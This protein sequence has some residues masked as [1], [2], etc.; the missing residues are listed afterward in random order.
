[1]TALTQHRWRPDKLAH[2]PVIGF[3][4]QDN[5]RD[6]EG[7][8]KTMSWRPG[9]RFETVEVCN[10]YGEPDY[11]SETVADGVGSQTLTVVSI[12][13]PGRFP[14]RVFY[15]RTWTDPKGKTFGK[16][17]LRFITAGAFKTLLRG[18]RHEFI[19]SPEHSVPVSTERRE[20]RAA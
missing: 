14:T 6:G 20:G 16:T 1:M 19:L 13:K 5:F 18:Y 8:A 4:G 2:Q 10:R 3:Y 7:P 9:V 15:T 17:K 11:N 12:H